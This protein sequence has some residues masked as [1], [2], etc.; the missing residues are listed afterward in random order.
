MRGWHG[1][2]QRHSL[3]SRGVKTSGLRSNAR[4][5][6]IYR[7]RGRKYYRDDR[8]REF[9]NTD[10]PHDMIPFDCYEGRVLQ[11]KASGRQN[12]KERVQIHGM[13]MSRWRCPECHR[14]L[15][16]GRC[17]F[18]G[19]VRDPVDVLESPRAQEIAIDARIWNVLK[20]NPNI[21]IPGLARKIGMDEMSMHAFLG[22]TS[23][24]ADETTY[25]DDYRRAYSLKPGR[26]D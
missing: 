10:D 23:D 20:E 25:L 22:R 8:L 4:I 14:G 18:H 5:L 7:F 11:M 6:P 12:L 24:E 17:T 26:S 9:R 21:T 3:A 13:S 1:E 19:T 2:P 16:D 15:R